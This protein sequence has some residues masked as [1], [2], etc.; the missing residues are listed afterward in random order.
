MCSEFVNYYLDLFENFLSENDYSIITSIYSPDEFNNI[1]ITGNEISGKV[2][3][4]LV[5]ITFKL[6]NKHEYRSIKNIIFNI[7]EI[8]DTL[9]YELF[10]SR[11]KKTK[12][13]IFSKISFKCNC[14][15]R[16]P[17]RHSFLLLYHLGYLLNDNPYLLFKVKGIDLKQIENNIKG[18]NDIQTISD[19]LSSSQ[20]L[21]EDYSNNYQTIPDLFISNYSLIKN[22]KIASTYKGILEVLNENIDKKMDVDGLM[23]ITN[24]RQTTKFSKSN[25]F[26][27]RWNA[28]NVT[29]LSININNNYSISKITTSRNHTLNNYKSPTYLLLFLYELVHSDFS[30]YNDV[31]GFI[32]ELYDLC[33]KLISHNAIIPELFKCNDKISVRWIPQTSNRL[34][35]EIINKA[36]TRAPQN[37][38]MFNRENISSKSIVIT[39]ISLLISGLLN[40]IKKDNLIQTQLESV[41][42][43]EKVNVRMIED[44]GEIL[45]IN[46]DLNLLKKDL[47]YVLILVISQYNNNFMLELFVK[48]DNENMNICDVLENCNSEIEEKLLKDIKVI[49]DYYHDINHV[50]NNRKLILDEEKFLEFFNDTLALIENMGVRIILPKILKNIL[51]P[52]IKLEKSSNTTVSHLTI[53]NIAKYDW[54]ITLGDTCISKEEFEGLLTKNKRLIKISDEYFNVDLNEIKHIIKVLE[55]LPSDMNVMDLINLAYTGTINNVK[56]EV[57]E[58]IINQLL[59]INKKDTPLPVTLNATLREYQIIGYQWILQNFNN[60]FGC[61]LADDMG[62]GKTLQTLSV[63]L[64]FKE[65]DEINDSKIL[66]IVPTS[67]LYNWQHEIDKFT[68]Q[69]KTR[70]YHGKHRS[71]T[72]NVYDILL[73]SYGMIRSDKNK[74]TRRK[75]LL[76][77]IDEAQNI[78]NPTTKQSKAVKSIKSKY[79]LA[80]TGTPIEN[81]LS[82]YWSIFDFVNKDY[83]GSLKE[84]TKEY[85]IPIEQEHDSK[86]LEHLKKLTQTF[87]LRRMKTQKEIIKDLPEKNVNDIYCNLS[88]KQAALYEAVLDKYLDMIEYEQPRYRRGHILELITALKQICNHPAQYT[89]NRNIKAADSGKL[90]TLIEILRTIIENDE[91]TLI[92]TQYVKTGHILRQVIDEKL[93]MNVLFLHGGLSKKKRDDYIRQFQEEDNI[94]IFIL[95]LKAGGVGLNLTAACNVIHYDLWWNPA[96]ENQATDRAYRIGQNHNVMVYRFITENTLEEHINDILSTKKKLTDRTIQDTGKFITQMSNSQ[97]NELLRLR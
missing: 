25:S 58:N 62:L 76:V 73:T 27:D 96:V 52:R 14:N 83:L 38:V 81:R 9:S 19:I 57:D 79:R 11:L 97:L 85:A 10:I 53:N 95:S 77:V 65:N 61:I 45:D 40:I 33:L 66:I 35:D 88:L 31:T 26:L 21:Q 84:F 34:V 8:Y 91:K 51:K 86:K 22:T 17:C 70:I 4:K 24:K 80:L 44:I 72:G 1:T 39:F 23:R 2:N 36:S 59:S 63:I 71:L 13:N 48:H 37:L 47:N 20:L 69:L 82:E 12:I 92:F 42:L 60:D 16:N 50:I 78:K 54:M 90:T 94:R 49:S 64:H 30:S 46:K 3:N 41:M 93:H 6:F 75:W 68:P 67:L 15:K 74:F 55:S 43:E 18:L 29:D 56:I 5:K 7:L 87:I 89:K 32:V 28:Y